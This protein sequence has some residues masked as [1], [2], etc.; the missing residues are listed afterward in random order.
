MTEFWEAGL[1]LLLLLG[2]SAAGLYLRPLLPER[3]WNAETND[4]VRLVGTMLV[5]FAAIVLGLLITTAKSSF[6]TVEN[7]VRGYGVDIIELD[8]VLRQYGPETDPIRK[9]L[10][11]YTASAIATTWDQE[12][13]PPGDY[14]PK[15][16]PRGASDAE[17]ENSSL[18]EILNRIEMDLRRFEPADAMHRKLAADSIIKFERLL[19]R[20]WKL[21]EEAHTTISVQFLGMLSLWMVVVFAGFG[22]S[23]PRNPLV[24]IML[25]LGAFSIASSIFV[26]LDLGTPFNGFFAVSSEPL[27]Q[28][29]DH[30]NR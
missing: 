20:R 26:I 28:A 1:V 18:G 14:Y 7:D 3:H 9:E 21:I 13:P 4:L 5:T 10:R 24:I 15:A 25:A 12:A 6:D 23:A 22:I 17:M 19:N 29:L 30:L 2:S 27:R 16:P 11:A 8:R